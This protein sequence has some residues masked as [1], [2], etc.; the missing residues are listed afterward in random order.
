MKFRRFLTLFVSLSLF[1]FTSVFGDVVFPADAFKVTLT[2]MSASAKF[3]FQMSAQGTFYVDWGDNSAVETITRT[4]TTAAVYEHTYAS[5]GTYNVR[6]TGQATAYSSSSTTAAISFTSS[7]SRTKMTKIE[8]DLGAMFPMVGSLPRFYRTFSGCSGLAGSIPA[9]LFAGLKN[10]SF[11]SDNIRNLATNMFRETFQGCSGLTGQIPGTLFS[12]VAGG[13]KT[14][15]LAMKEG[16]FA[17]TFKGCASLQSIGPGL[18]DGFGH[19]VKDMFAGTFEDCT[20]LTGPS[21]TRGEIDGSGRA[22]LYVLFAGSSAS[23]THV[24]NCYKNA[25][26]LDDY[27]MIPQMWGGNP[28]VECPKPDAGENAFALSWISSAPN[29]EF[30]FQISAKGTFYVD[31]GDGS[32]VQTITRT[33]T[34]ANTYTHKYTGTGKYNITLTGKATGY[35][36]DSATPAISF[37][38]SKGKDQIVSINGSLGAIFPIV[39]SSDTGSP[40]FVGTFSGCSNIAGSI[41]ANLF[42]G[43]SG[44]PVKNMF[45]GTFKDCKKLS[46]S[47]PA[48]L[49]SGI[50]GAPA[51]YMFESTFYGCSGLTGAIPGALFSGITGAPAGR[52]FSITFY[53]CSGLTGAI[54]GNLFGGI[55]GAPADAMFNGTFRG[56]GGLTGQIPGTLFG[57][58]SGPAK[59]YM[60]RTTFYDCGGLTGSIPANLFAGISG[61]PKVEMFYAVFQGCSKLTGQIPGNLFGGINGA[62]ADSMFAYAFQSCKGL[63]GQIPGTLFSGISGA[64]AKSMFQG[65][66]TSCSGLTGQIPGNLFSGVAGAA[67]E[68]MFWYTFASCSGLTG[69]GDGLFDGITGSLPAGSFYGTF[70]SGTGL[71]GPSAKSNGQYLYQKFTGSAAATNYCY[72]NASGLDDY[73]A[74]PTVW[75]GGT[76]EICGHSPKECEPGTYLPANKTVCVT[77][78]NGYW[79]PGNVGNPYTV[80]PATTDQ[81]INACS[82][83]PAEDI[84]SESPRSARGNC[85]KTGMPWPVANGTGTQTCFSNASGVYNTGCTNKVVTSCQGDYVMVSNNAC[86]LPEII[87]PCAAG[88]YLPKGTQ[89]CTTC[90]AGSW[91][92]GGDLVVY[93][94]MDVG[95]NECPA[96]VI[97]GSGDLLN[98]FFSISDQH[99]SSAAGS[100]ALTDCYHQFQ[101]TDTFPSSTFPDFPIS[102]FQR[103]YHSGDTEIDNS[104]FANGY[105]G[106]NHLCFFRTTACGPGHWDYM[107]AGNGWSIWCQ[108]AGYGA[109]CEGL[110][111]PDGWGSGTW[112][113]DDGTV[114]VDTGTWNRCQEADN[115]YFS[116]EPNVFQTECPAGWSGSDIPRS[117]RGKCYKIGVPWSFTGGTGTQTCYFGSI[118]YTE[119]CKNKIIAECEAGFVPIMNDGDNGVP[120]IIACVTTESIVIHMPQSSPEAIIFNPEDSQWTDVKKQSVT[121]ISVDNPPEEQWEYS[122]PGSNWASPLEGNVVIAT[123]SNPEISPIAATL[124]AGQYSATLAFMSDESDLRTIT[125]HLPRGIPDTIIFNIDKGVWTDIGGYEVTEIAVLQNVLEN[126][127]IRYYLTGDNWTPQ[128]GSKVTIIEP[129]NGILPIAQTLQPG[130]YWATIEFKDEIVIGTDAC[131]PGTYLPGSPTFSCAPCLTGYY[132][133]YFTL[134]D[135]S[136]SVLDRGLVACPEKKLFR[137]YSDSNAKSV[138][139]CFTTVP[140]ALVGVGEI[141][142]HRCYYNSKAGDY[143]NCSLICHRGYEPSQ[144]GT[145]CVPEG[146]ANSCP[147]NEYLSELFDECTACPDGGTSPAGT[148]DIEKCEKNTDI[149]G[150]TET[151]SFEG[152]ELEGDYTDCTA[153]CWAEDYMQSPDGASCIPSVTFPA[154]AFT[155]TL[156]GMSAS[157]KFDFQM[158]AQG[159]FYVDWGDNSAVETITRT[160]TTLTKYE[161]TYTAAGNYTV[162][163]TG[164]ATGYN[165]GG[166]TAAITFNNSINKTR[167]TGIA[168]DL[169]KIFPILNTSNTGS[170]RFYRTFYGCTGLTGSIPGNLFASISGAPAAYMF[171]ETFSGCSGL[172]GSIPGNLFAS[173]SGKP[174][175]SMFYYTFSGCSGLNGE[176]PSNLFAGISGAPAQDMLRGTFQNC[177]GLTGSIPSNLFAGISGKPANYMFCQTFAGCSSLSGSIPGNLFAGISGAPAAFM[178]YYTFSGC[179]G[180]TGEIPSNLFAG[181][182]GKPAGN[183]F[184]STFRGCKQ[185]TGS[186]P[187]GLFGTFD[188]PPAT[189]MFSLTF[190]G[191]SGLTGS[192]PSNLFAGISGAP[193]TEMFRETFASCKQL[194]SIGDGLFDGI[195]GPP[196]AGMFLRTFEGCSNLTGPSATGKDAGGSERKFLYKKW[197]DATSGQI[198]NCY[199]NVGGLSDY[200]DIPEAWGTLPNMC[201]F[202]ENAFTINIDN[203]GISG[204]PFYVYISAAGDFYIDWGDGGVQHIV[205]ENTNFDRYSHGYPSG[206]YTIKL[207]GRA[208]GYS[209]SAT[210]AALSFTPANSGAGA[211]TGIAGDLGKI[212]PILDTPAAGTFGTPRFNDTFKDQ[213]RLVGPIPEN[214]FA[215]LIGA[216]VENMFHSTFQTCTSLTGEVPGKLFAGIN[217]PMTKNLFTATFNGCNLS[218]IGDGLFDGFSGFPPQDSSLSTTYPFFST[219]AGCNNLVGPSATSGDINGNNRM[220]LYK[221]WTSSGGISAPYTYS[222]AKYLSDYCMIPTYWGGSSS[223]ICDKEPTCKLGEYI[224]GTDGACG[225]CPEN[226]YCPGDDEKHNCPA[227]Y[228]FSPAGSTSINDC[229]A[230]CSGP[231]CPCNDVAIYPPVLSNEKFGIT[232]DGTCLYQIT[233]AK[234]YEATN[235]PGPN[236]TCVSAGTTSCNPGEHLF[237]GECLPCLEGNYCEGDGTLVLCPEADLALFSN[238]ILGTEFDSYITITGKPTI[239]SNPPMSSQ[240]HCYT[241][242]DPNKLTIKNGTITGAHMAKAFWGEITYHACLWNVDC[243]PGFQQAGPYIPLCLPITSCEPGQYLSEETGCT[244]C[245]AGHFCDGTGEPEEC[246]AP[247]LFQFSHATIYEY[248]SYVSVPGTPTIGSSTPMSSKSNCYMECD[249]NKLSITNGTVTGAMVNTLAMWTPTENSYL[250]CYWNVECDSGFYQPMQYLPLCMPTNPP[251]RCEPGFYIPAGTSACNAPCESGYYCP[252]GDFPP[253][254]LQDMGKMACSAL[255]LEFGLGLDIPDTG[256]DAPRTAPENCYATWHWIETGNGELWNQHGTGTLTCYYKDSNPQGDPRDKFNRDCTDNVA[257]VKGYEKLYG[258]MQV[259]DTLPYCSLI[260]APE[261]CPEDKYIEDNVCVSCPATHPNSPDGTTSINQ[262]YADCTGGNSSAACLQCAG[263]MPPIRTGMESLALVRVD[264]GTPGTCIWHVTCNSGYEVQG[265]NPGPHPTCASS[266][267]PVTCDAGKYLPG[268]TSQCET[269]PKGSWCPGGEEYGTMETF[270]RGI[271]AC[272]GA[273]ATTETTGSSAITACYI[274]EDIPG[275]HGRRRCHHTGVGYINCTVTSCDNGYYVTAGASTC[276]PCQPGDFCSGGTVTSCSAA[277]GGTHTL[278]DSGATAIGNCYKTCPTISVQ[279]AATVSTPNA[280]YPNT[281]CSYSV[282]CISGF[283]PTNNPGPNPTCEQII[284]TCPVGQYPLR[285]VCTTC[286]AGSYCDGT[287]EPEPCLDGTYCPGGGGEPKQCPESHPKS[288]APRSSISDCYK[289]CIPDKADFP[290]ATTVQA[291]NPKAGYDGNCDW[292]VT[293]ENDFKAFNNGN[294]N[295]SCSQSR[296]KCIAGYYLFGGTSTCAECLPNS[297]CLGGSFLQQ[298][299]S[300]GLTACST[301]AGGFYPYSD[302]R[303]AKQ[304]DCFNSIC[305]AKTVA[306]ANPTVVQ[307]DAPKIYYDAKTCTYNTVNCGYGFALQGGNTDNPTCVLGGFPQKC[308]PGQH[309]PANSKTC[310]TCPKNSWCQGNEEFASMSS[311]AQGAR[312]CDGGGQTL[313][314]GSSSADQCYLDKATDNG[315]QRC[316]GAPG[317]TTNCSLTSCNAGY[318]ESGGNCIE[319]EDGWYSPD[320]SKTRTQCPSS[321]SGSTAPRAAQT[322]CYKNCVT[323]SLP[324]N[325]AT[326]TST[327]PD[328]KVYWKGSAY[329]ACSWSVTC[330]GDYVPTGS[331]GANPTCSQQSFKCDPGQYLPSSAMS[332]DDCIANNFC[333]GLTFTSSQPSTRG[334]NSCSS[335]GDGTFTQSAAKAKSATECYKVCSSISVPNSISVTP[336]QVYF[337]GDGACKYKVTCQ[338]GFTPEGD[339]TA[340]PKCVSNG[341]PPPGTVTCS[342]GQYLPANGQACAI[343]VAGNYCTGGTFQTS[344]SIQ[345]LSACPMDGTSP[346]GATSEYSCFKQCSLTVDNA[347]S[348]VPVADKVYWNGTSY[349][350]SCSFNVT[351]KSGY[352]SETGTG[353]A[354][355]CVSDTRQCTFPNADSAVQKFANGTWGACEPVKCKAGFNLEN[356]NCVTNEQSCPIANGTGIREWIPSGTSGGKWTACEAIAC[357][358]GYTMDKSQTNDKVSPCGA[359]RNMFGP[360]GKTIAANGYIEDCRIESCVAQGELY[361]LTNN[362]CVQICNSGREDETGIMLWNSSSRKCD[363]TCKP[364]YVSW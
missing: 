176:I 11:S 101:A 359:C 299:S 122:I 293:C 341:T 215:S 62:P 87:V 263:N 125:I 281:A 221:K 283:N 162:K 37:E 29:S 356:K 126:P 183:M 36:S 39:N 7:A 151:C 44:A 206:T 71:T 72:L 311:S 234:G 43:I 154:D 248:P 181:I 318:Y 105:G 195:S 296:V 10:P 150:G 280:Y 85:Y 301:L 20:G 42:A 129:Y 17:G 308:A 159:A 246:P 59:D 364:G 337:G 207:M 32:A 147:V 340:N 165:P 156:T 346:A 22:F 193:A 279:N 3:D 265:V 108:E 124:P 131:A 287:G 249:K 19:I 60:F 79:C 222:G 77:C 163:M 204:H 253:S 216:P 61:A 260:S 257:C 259:W 291:V 104:N 81:G 196:A 52:M 323:P 99:V 209:P 208:T 210:V 243:D 23:A 321:A 252:G 351:C 86:V 185:L 174:A 288:A 261:T 289:D 218:R 228:S 73:C 35:S 268:G 74:I 148:T 276:S 114:W 304:S 4:N 273:G 186:I 236:P 177:T 107:G 58:I 190:Q 344:S 169:G 31:W 336:M 76:P 88:E 240:S 103:C 227:E 54:P 102:F 138:E 164:L 26:G 357:D 235:N 1:A 264:Y 66:F 322:S 111:G 220:P 233:C 145:T 348:V 94:L 184:D 278:S 41:P 298:A 82:G 63:T 182:S 205:K 267:F 2:G 123:S 95:R 115:G 297:F 172:T 33:V 56:C 349:S 350:P 168:G 179:S 106:R 187:S 8:G 121:Q 342:M 27:C 245:P 119:N 294:P 170:P 271:N 274:D 225:L 100:A 307:P 38:N 120:E 282:T 358:P 146:S 157:A 309:L 80:I 91:C 258:F 152:D 361:N 142:E 96:P 355:L 171:Y 327:D 93:N 330:N 30:S 275:G 68:N 53:G 65:T 16:I 295:A 158:S 153:L 140:I 310:A 161:H 230:F 21:A 200:C 224:S 141:G 328:S 75:S 300:Q 242:C 89:T 270:D 113:H 51:E 83:A 139:E 180:L 213:N 292:N 266:T 133:P 256:S 6:M 250:Y 160:D 203:T 247:D 331:P 18:F 5:A 232:A 360:D 191:C 48:G 347:E 155:V 325:A 332:C 34:T 324:A 45:Q 118:G 241:E 284:V 116:E 78:P 314:T 110:A 84:G 262:C 217:G 128:K 167:M 173:I 109:A 178:F 144:D 223:A 67:K 290:N 338:S 251:V 335:A 238:G 231:S 197:P 362:E 149:E 326:I 55:V 97:F 28:A 98:G 286:P 14:G 229:Y 136:N 12:S 315:K 343:C 9:N 137:I 305:S 13:M 188:G 316:W 202:L 255:L 317:Y 46:G 194:T 175:D 269:C 254:E 212:F 49:F 339:E 143:D 15:L 199:K 302:A 363:R 192:I 333:P 127:W 285:G 237:N 50:S 312:A 201:E 130:E 272:T 334:L 112:T 345:G 57:G 277:T 352:H 306:N 25:T 69:I 70:L 303:A 353:G 117:G 239:G 135:G 219:F 329:P 313:S 134:Y 226:S 211:I 198:G 90:P 244:P 166:M 214:L 132:C 354:Q 92:P 319:V 24:G 40:R 47:I 189:S 320:G 64:P